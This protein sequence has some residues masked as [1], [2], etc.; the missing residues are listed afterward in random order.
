MQEETKHLHCYCYLVFYQIKSPF[1]QSE[2]AC[3]KHDSSL[4]SENLSCKK[5]RAKSSM[6]HR[7]EIKAGVS[8]HSESDIAART[9][10]LIW[11]R[12]FSSVIYG[13]LQELPE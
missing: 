12:T 2:Q 6:Q 3:L 9:S 10:L 4:I 5:T 8:L 1:P 7:L 11:I 13:S